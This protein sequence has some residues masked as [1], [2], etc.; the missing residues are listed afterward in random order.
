M[1]LAVLANLLENGLVELKLFSN[2]PFCR[3][4]EGL[5][6]IG[7]KAKF[8]VCFPYNQ[9]HEVWTFEINENT[10]N[11]NTTCTYFLVTEYGLIH[12]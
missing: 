11:Y 12:G 5:E 10:E 8:K 7:V 2:W 9:L 4:G 6:E 3:K 1:Y